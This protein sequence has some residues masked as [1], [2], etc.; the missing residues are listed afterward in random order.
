MR[1]RNIKAQF[2]SAKADRE[3]SKDDL[4]RYRELFDQHI[5]SQPELDRRQ[6]LYITAQQKVAALEAQLGQTDN[7]LAYTDLLAD[8]DGVVTALEVETGQ[9][10]VAGQP[11][12]KLAQLDEKEIHIDIPEHRVAEYQFPAES[13][14]DLVG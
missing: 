12:I 10:V 3:Y 5:I 14:R 4:I 13:R 9:V 7:Q 1:N 8:R 2:I 11:V 6:T